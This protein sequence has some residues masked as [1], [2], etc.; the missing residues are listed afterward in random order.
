[1][2]S[3]A[4]FLSTTALVLPFIATEAVAGAFALREQS[5]ESQGV[6]FAGAAAP[7]H[8]PSAMF[9]NPAT[10]T[11]HKGLVAENGLSLI[12]PHATFETDPAQSPLAASG[13]GNGGD[14]GIAAWLPSFYAAF[15]AQDG[16][17]L[18]LSVNA[19]FGLGTKADTPWVGQTDHLEAGM[20]AIAVTPVAAWKINDMVSIGAGVTL[21]HASVELSRMPMIG[22]STFG[23]GKIEG[24]DL[25]IG[26]VAGITL[27]PW[28]GTEIGLGYRSPISHALDGTQTLRTT[29]GAVLSRQ[30]ITAEVTVPETVTLGL[31]QKISD[32][33]T[34]LGGAEWANWDRIGTVPVVADDGRT[35][36]LLDFQYA[37]GWFLSV[38]GE[39]AATDRLTLRS[40]VAY[41][42]SPVQDAHRSMRLPD[43]DRF[44]LSVGAS[45]EA[46]DALSIDVAY[47]RILVSDSGIA[48]PGNPATGMV[49]YGG[50]LEASV[51][52]LTAAVRYRFGG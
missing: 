2:T 18:G 8:G 38:G 35:T 28:E 48:M 29:S 9:W 13:F 31:R 22:P 41:E 50:D 6:S 12:A 32:R 37:D 36:S 33:F 21:Q 17:H 10:I 27:T 16:L 44:W 34:L 1:M 45:Y 11:A 42:W 25:D 30:D 51:D 4:L 39:Y 46:T 7:G 3:K 24:S 26:A 15:E 20:Q 43:D 14:V 23:V 47:T 5:A 49:G 19:P 52:I 40:G